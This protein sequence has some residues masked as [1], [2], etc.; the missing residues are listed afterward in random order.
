[1]PEAW[2][3]VQLDAAVQANPK[4]L[5][6]FSATWCAPCRL[7]QPEIEKLEK[8]G[9]I[10]VIRVDYDVN[11]ALAQTTYGVSEI[12]TVLAYKQGKQVMRL[13]G[14]QTAEV[15]RGVLK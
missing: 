15:M 11:R 3:K 2:T 8:E 4:A 10:K 13:E 7:M 1:M 6:D 12:P 9:R 14:M 5:I